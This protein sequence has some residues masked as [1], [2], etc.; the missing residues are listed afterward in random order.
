M[1]PIEFLQQNGYNPD[2][3]RTGV[4][5]GA[6]GARSAIKHHHS[7]ERVQGHKKVVKKTFRLRDISVVR[8]EL[9]NEWFATGRQ[10]LNGLFLPYIM[11]DIMQQV[12]GEYLTKVDF[13]KEEKMH[14]K[15]ML[16]L[17][18]T[19]NLNF[20]AGFSEEQKDVVIEMMDAFSEYIHN[21]LEV[22]RMQIMS[23]IMD[24]TGEFRAACGA[25]CVCKLLISQSRIAWEGM[26]KNTLKNTD[27]FYKNLLGMEKHIAELM[28]N[29]FL[30]ESDRLNREV[31]F[32]N[33][34]NV[35][36]AEENVVKKI[37]KFLKEYEK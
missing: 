36:L 7:N 30:R 35:R 33:E 27:V 12:N 6:V 18:H 20:F 26:Y 31:K 3:F 10:E 14:Y 28:N 29:Y 11:L 23:C 34:A 4:P 15:K 24:L 16:K 22:F 32:S 8:Q 13:A 17:Y 19:F 9:F 5:Q 2:N 25:L 37:L 1:N 21:E